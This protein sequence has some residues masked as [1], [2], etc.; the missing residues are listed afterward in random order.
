M[1][2]TVYFIEG[3]GVGAECFGAA[4]PVWDAAV[5]LAH[6]GCGID[7]IEV[8][9]GEKAVAA[10][11]E[12][13]PEASIAMLREARTAIK[14]PLGTPVGT[15]FRS[16]NVTLRQ[17]FDLYACIRPIQ[18][19]QGIESPLRRPDLVDMVV[20]R[21]NTEDVYAGIEYA[22]GSPEAKRLIAFLRDELGADVDGAAGVG[23]K[24][25]TPDGC[26]RLVRRAIRLALAEA[27]PSV[28]LVHKGNIMK[29]TEGGFR[30]WGYDVARE[31]FGGDIVTEAEA[32]TGKTGRVILK[33]RIADAMFQDTLI[34][35]QEFSVIAAPNLNG[36]Y[37]SDALAAQ[38]GGL[39][40]A[41]GANM[42]DTLGFFEATHGT[43]PDIAGQDKV[44][45]GSLILSGAMM[46]EYMGWPEAGR[47]VRTAVAQAVAG[48]RV[49][50]DLA[51]QMPGATTVGCKEFGE[52]VAARL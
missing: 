33:D 36:D 9:A 37:L 28:T 31:E 27:R 19:F 12:L 14:G 47:R 51:R 20:V 26:K 8:L 43:A 24:P 39:G 52:I 2:K 38:V 18:Y 46:L 35:P 3:D 6:K 23:I 21:E 15:G 17:A 1:R 10:C 44:N 50:A 34:K 22:S 4:R 30:Q 42:S 16:L 5:A 45:P 32:K 25:M 29:F 13:L 7:W 41:P 11:G 40:L 48:R 49:T